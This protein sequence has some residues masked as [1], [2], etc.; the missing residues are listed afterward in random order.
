MKYNESQYKCPICKSE[1]RLS[2]NILKKVCICLDQTLLYNCYNDLLYIYLNK[3]T[4]RLNFAKNSTVIFNH[5]AE[6][7]ISFDYIFNPDKVSDINYLLNI[8]N[9]IEI[10]N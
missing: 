3:Y 8:I 4:F 9:N 5:N 6:I 1:V 7:K 2:D 10:Y